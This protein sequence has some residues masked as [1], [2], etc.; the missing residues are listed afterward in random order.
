[1]SDMKN[2]ELITFDCYGTLID[3]EAGIIDA[4]QPLLLTKGV[5]A[6]EVRI[7]ELYAKLE[8]ELESGDYRSYREVL[9]GVIDGMAR[10]LSF[11][12]DDTERNTLVDSFTKWPPFQDTIGSLCRLHSKYKLGIISNV[13]EDLFAGTKQVLQVSFDHVVTASMAGIYKP[14]TDMFEFALSQFDVPKENI[15]HTAQSIYHDHVPGKKLGLRTCWINR[16]SRVKGRGVSLPAE[17]TPDLEFPDLKSFT[18][19]MLG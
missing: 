9:R 19:Q 8:A 11:E 4:V 3:W 13:D 5:E 14:N 12:V 6:T 10:E 16:S 2:I 17:A 1:M 7:L 18:A 15:L